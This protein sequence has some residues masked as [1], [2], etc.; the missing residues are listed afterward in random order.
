MEGKVADIGCG[1]KPY[2]RYFTAAD[3]YTGFDLST[4]QQADV[5]FDGKTIP[6]ANAAFNHIISSE[7]LEHVFWPE[8]W[9]SELNRILKPGGLLLLTSPFLFHEHEAPFDYVRYSSYGLQYLLEQNGFEIV[10]FKKA[11]A[12][13]RCV[14]LQ[15]NVLWWTSFKKH[16]PRPV[17][18]VLSWFF[19][20]PANIMGLLLGWCWKSTGS[21]YAGNMVLCRKSAQPS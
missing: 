18:F 12:G 19:F 4:N 14:L 16:L 11:V 5:A 17:A 13:L 3:S 10:E 7:V 8:S 9:L 6:A 2:E 1:S 15:W 20:F 21:F